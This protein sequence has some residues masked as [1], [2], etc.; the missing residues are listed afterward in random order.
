MDF[1]GQEEGDKGF[2][3]SPS[4][5]RSVCPT[6]QPKPALNSSKV[7]FLPSLIMMFKG[8]FNLHLHQGGATRIQS[9][10]Y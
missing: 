1:T 2:F 9:L 10:Y 8:S 5:A 6:R 4:R 7:G 3:S